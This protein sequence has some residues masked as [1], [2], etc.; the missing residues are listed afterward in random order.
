MPSPSTHCSAPLADR[1]PLRPTTHDLRPRQPGSVPGSSRVPSGLIAGPFRVLLGPISG[2]FG[3]PFGSLSGPFPAPSPYNHMTQVP[4]CRPFTATT[5]P[6]H[7]P[8][9]PFS[10]P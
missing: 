4:P 8:P 10:V 5:P 1:I 7:A 3:V 9:T 6:P 2:P